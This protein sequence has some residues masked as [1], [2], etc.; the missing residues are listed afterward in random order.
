[1]KLQS[2][3][4][5]HTDSSSSVCVCSMYR[6]WRFSFLRS[7]LMPE[8][9]KAVIGESGITFSSDS[10]SVAWCCWS[11]LEENNGKWKKKKLI[12]QIFTK[13][14]LPNMELQKNIGIKLW[15]MQ[16]LAFNVPNLNIRIREVLKWSEYQ[17]GNIIVRSEVQSVVGGTLR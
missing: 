9:E 7:R 2:L 6:T 8:K 5:V 4:F 15:E 11:F 3:P 17:L 16:F 1:M 14:S 12:Q 10:R 13:T